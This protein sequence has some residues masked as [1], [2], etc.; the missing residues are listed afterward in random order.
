[1][2]SFPS[3]GQVAFGSSLACAALTAG[4][5]FAAAGATTAVATVALGALAVGAGGAG[6]AAGTAYLFEENCDLNEYY[7]NFKKHAGVV[8][9][10]EAQRVAHKVMDAFVNGACR[11]LSRKVDKNVSAFLG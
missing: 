3:I 5:G 8:I 10:A 7:G 4:A 6:I 11:A 9:G 2:S 1:M